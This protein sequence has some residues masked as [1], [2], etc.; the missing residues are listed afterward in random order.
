MRGGQRPLTTAHQYFCLQTNPICSGTGSIGIGRFT[1]R[2]GASP[3][4]L[5]R[6]YGLRIDYRQCGKPRVVVEPPD[7]ALL[8]GGRRLPHVYD[9][10]P[11][12]LCLYLPG[13]GEW[14]PTKR[15]DVTVVPWSVLW[16]FYFEEW[17]ISDEW[18]GGGVHPANE[19]GKGAND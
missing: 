3:T 19:D 16:L 8:A 5:S 11:P 14:T 1:W 18:K 6:Q 17:L 7:L 4:P 10:C 9:Q 13:T 15:L 12:R 2:F